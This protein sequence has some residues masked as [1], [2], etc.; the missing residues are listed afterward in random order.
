MVSSLDGFIAK[1]DGEV[2]WM[3][4]KDTY[5]KGITLSQESIDA[6]LQKID[7]YIIGARTYENAL[8]L[9]WPYGE[10]PVI[11]LTHKEL[12]NNRESVNFYSGSILQLIN[13]FLTP[14]YQEI[15][16]V[17]GVAVVKE[18]IQK[19]IAE[20]LI[21]SIMPILLGE[22]LPFFDAISQETQLH[23]KDVT[24]YKDGMVEMWYEIKK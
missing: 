24:T 18:F 17:G 7:C 2:S 22:G 10:T 1:K 11:V 20:E 9:G 15:W 12:K 8:E 3:Q 23:L 19:K 5:E 6:F 4:S 16:V 14:N 13:N 21:I